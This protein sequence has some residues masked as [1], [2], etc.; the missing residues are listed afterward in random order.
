[1]TCAMIHQVVVIE[2]LFAVTM[3]MGVALTLSVVAILAV[4]FRE[5]ISHRSW[6]SPRWKSRTG[7]RLLDRAAAF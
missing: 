3:M 2:L 6:A 7:S 1:M 5:R 4:L